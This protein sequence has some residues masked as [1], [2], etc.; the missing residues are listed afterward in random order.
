MELNEFENI[1]Q[2]EVS[3]KRT[4]HKGKKDGRAQLHLMYRESKQVQYNLI[5]FSTV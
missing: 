5:K 2:V 3:G 4:K 1:F